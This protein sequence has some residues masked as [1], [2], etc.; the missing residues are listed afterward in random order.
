MQWW[1]YNREHGWVLLDRT[2]PANRPGI[3]GDLLFFRCRDSTTYTT[4]RAN[5]NPPLYM[6]AGNYI[7][8]LEA[9]VSAGATEELDRL[10]ARWPEFHEEIGRQV[11]ETEAQAEAERVRI[12][13]SRLKAA[14]DLKK[15]E[16]VETHSAFLKAKGLPDAGVVEVLL[17]KGRRIGRCAV[18]EKPLDKTTEVQCGGCGQIICACGGCACAVKAQASA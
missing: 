2:V 16:I 1:G 5:W 18:C 3:K 11:R 6:F 17:T 13:E 10:K 8:D 4:K 15:R 14:A 7:N 12:E 9:D